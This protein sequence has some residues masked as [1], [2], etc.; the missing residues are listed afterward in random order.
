MVRLPT[1]PFGPVS[2]IAAIAVVPLGLLRARHPQCVR[3]PWPNRTTRLIPHSS[4]KAT[5]LPRARSFPMVL[6]PI[7]RV[8]HGCQAGP[9]RSHGE[10]F[11][12]HPILCTVLLNPDTR[13]VQ[14]DNGISQSR[15]RMLFKMFPNILFRRFRYSGFAATVMSMGRQ[16]TFGNQLIEAIYFV[17]RS[18]EHVSDESCVGCITNP[19]T[20]CS[21]T[22]ILIV[23]ANLFTSSYRY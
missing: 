5:R 23:F 21:R 14:F 7:F 16:V 13:Q 3:A 11:S 8:L 9:A 22:S 17:F 2:L 4:R 18:I 10:S 19:C 12:R 20:T 15:V 6:L 1:Y